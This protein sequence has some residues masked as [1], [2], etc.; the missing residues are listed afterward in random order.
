MT[1]QI[2]ILKNAKEVI[3]FFTSNELS[4]D[5]LNIIAPFTIRY[6]RHFFKDSYECSHYA[7]VWVESIRSN[8]T[9]NNKPK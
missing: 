2:F 3:P 4:K 8:L 5:E 6:E 7:S 9:E 1:Y